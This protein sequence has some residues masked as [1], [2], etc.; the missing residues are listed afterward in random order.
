MARATVR[1]PTIARVKQLYK[2]PQHV[3]WADIEQRTL[4][5]FTPEHKLEVFNSVETYCFEKSFVEEAGSSSE[6]EKLRKR[7]LKCASEMF[8][9]NEEYSA[10]LDGSWLDDDHLPRENR[11]AMKTLTATYG[12]KYSIREELREAATKARNIMSELKSGPVGEFKTIAKD[13]EPVALAAFIRSVLEGADAEQ[14]R[15]KT[16]DA[17]EYT[18]WGISVGPNEGFASFCAVLLQRDV[19]IDQL[20]YAFQIER[21][22]Y[23][24][25]TI[26]GK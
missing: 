6:T 4:N 22:E 11:L 5:S 12:E 13:A 7:L 10:S 1:I 2:Y 18:R 19:L 26:G 23:A 14:A 20:K 3:N 21:S 8:A 9:I 17:L 24:F 15:S 16:N 25:G